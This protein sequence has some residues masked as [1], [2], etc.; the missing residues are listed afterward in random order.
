MSEHVN[1]EVAGAAA[2]IRLVRPAKKNA[3]TVAMYEALIDALD[4]FEKDDNVRV[5]S[6]RGG[7]DFTAGN[8]LNDF[9]ALSGDAENAPPLRFLRALRAF[10]KPVVA[11]VRGAAVGIG[12]TMLLHADCALAG[13]SAAFSLPFAKLGLVPEGA[14]SL[15]LPTFGGYARASWYLLTGET[16]DARIAAELGLVAKVVADTELEQAADNVVA[17]LAALP[18]EALRETKRLLRAPLQDAVTRVMQ[19]EA[20]SFALRLR[21]PEFHEAAMRLMKR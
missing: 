18:A 5:I 19:T 8:D 7:D 6:L 16:F 2:T 1:I 11:A 12:A 3:L 4:R 13:T 14:S 20:E 17:Q 9:L 10:P 21:S 15:L